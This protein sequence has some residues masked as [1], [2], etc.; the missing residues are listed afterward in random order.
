MFQQVL[1][2]QGT[3]LRRAVL[4][5]AVAHLAFAVAGLIANPDFSVGAE[6]TAEQVLGVDFNGWHAVAGILLWLPAFL[7]ARRT[8][9]TLWYTLAVIGASLA[10]AVWMLFDA[11]PLGL[12]VFTN[13][14]SDFVYH[15]VS[16]AILAAVIGAH[17]LLVRRRQAAVA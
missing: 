11:T 3:F 5:N 12:L 8:D 15:V 17:L 2:D 9:W 4:V 13:T 10:P 1:T 14:W 6:S 16:S 7:A